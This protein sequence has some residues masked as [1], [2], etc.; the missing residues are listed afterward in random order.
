VLRIFFASFVVMNIMPLLP[1]V[2]GM[3]GHMK[4]AAR[5][6]LITQALLMGAAVSAG[7]VVGGPLLF[8]YIGI[9]LHDLRIGGGIILLVFVTYD[10]LFST[11]QRK[12]QDLGDEVGIIPLGVPIL[13]GPATFATL[14]VMSNAHGRLAVLAVLA[15]N[16]AINW[17][18]AQNA[19]RLLAVL[20]ESLTLALGKL[21]SLFLAAIAVSMMRNGIAGVIQDLRAP[22]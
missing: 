14:L 9:T 19:H 16:V 15:A 8:S 13:M 10:L 4:P 1:V 5:S 7:L 22:V 6:K 21:Y 12:Q 11:S 20:G 18:L 2:V 3:T 17:I